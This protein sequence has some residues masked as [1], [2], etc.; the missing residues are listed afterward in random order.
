MYGLNEILL[1]SVETN[2]SD[3][4][5][6]V[7]R[8]P[9]YR[10]DGSLIPLKGE[11]LT[12]QTM[13]VLLM[14]IL[15]GRR[16]EELGRDGQ[17]DFAYAVAGMGRFR[18][19]VFRQRGTLAAVIRNLP[20]VIPKPQDLG[21][22]SE[23]VELCTKRRG[24]IL[25]TGPAGNGKSTTLA[26]LI[27]NINQK[28]ARHIITLEEPIEYL[29]KHERS[30][31]NQREIGTDAP[32]YSKALQAAVRQDPDVILVGEMN[33]METISMAI[34]AAE[35]GH[36]VLSSL[37]TIGAE[38]TIERIVDVFPPAKQQ[39]IRIQLASVLECI[40]SQQLL[41]RSDEEGRVAA[42]EILTVNQAVRS[43]IREDKV[44]QLRSVMQ[45]GRKLGMQTMDDAL[46][47]LYISRMITA[48]ETIMYAQDP[49]GMN[50][51][52][53]FMWL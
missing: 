46:Y 30:I 9:S 48:E 13:E 40:I 8:A 47:E 42:M 28:Y 51:R 52:I 49:L 27:Q 2:A 1:Q 17:T 19:N 23:V 39:Q 24:L 41:K 35:N 33:D 12:P 14:P 29:H 37:Y 26:S 43:L 31:V 6:T 36:L 53:N 32:N 16:R 50:K 22:P 18:V 7:G 11:K 34:N 3:I 20:Y 15:D 25:V 21:I 4:H 5:L 45:A 10:I 38:N 44:H